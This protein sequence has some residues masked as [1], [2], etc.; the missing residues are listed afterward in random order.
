MN[1]NIK[2]TH[3]ELTPAIKE[4]IEEKIGNLEKYITATD[5]RVEIDRDQHHH[6]G[7]VFRAEVN[8]FM[9]GKLI[10]AEARAEDI[11]AALDLTI[12]KL[13]E[14]ITKFK[15]KKSS[16]N[17]SLERKARKKDLVD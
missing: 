3:L 17:R 4:Y 9:G 12:P 2:A 8:M 13:K 6:T 11:Y 10:R 7:L 14:Q 1:I 15:N 5:A 16:V